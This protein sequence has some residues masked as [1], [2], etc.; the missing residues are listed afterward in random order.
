MMLVF[1]L[2]LWVG[3]LIYCFGGYFGLI[4]YQLV[5][6]YFTFC[7]GNEVGLI[8]YQ[9]VDI[10]LGRNIHS[11]VHV[12]LCVSVKRFGLLIAAQVSR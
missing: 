6:S 2:T 4:L 10:K 11:M 7:A 8:S 1:A 9:S 3:S 5:G 12:S